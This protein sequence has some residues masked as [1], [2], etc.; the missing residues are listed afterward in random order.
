L[1]VI[2]SSAKDSAEFFAVPPT[3]IPR[4]FDFPMLLRSWNTFG[5]ARYYLN[6]V[7]VAVGSVA[8]SIIFNGFAGYVLAKLKPRGH[9]IIFALVMGTL[10]MPNAVSMVPTYKNI[11]HFP[12]S[13]LPFGVNLLDTFWPMWLM[14]G[15]NAFLIIVF[16]GFFDGIATSF[17]EAARL[18]GCNDL[19]V[20]SKIV[21]PLSKPVM[22]TAIILQINWTWGDFFWPYMVLKDKAM[23]TVIVEVFQM[24]QALA[25]NRQI[26]LLT[27]A[28]L[29]PIIF[30]V[31]FQKYIMQGFTMSGLKG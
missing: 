20:F 3:I 22:F 7:Y 31:F 23:Y 18:D 4:S 27:F 6:T 30:F 1:W 9:T 28:L 25:V 29:P 14:S 12:F 5:L 24:Q 8:F 15:A 19:Q 17:I 11:I 13:F 2:V 21:L 26:V 10:L 16:K